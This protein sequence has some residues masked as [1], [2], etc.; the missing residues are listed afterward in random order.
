MV[1]SARLA[2]VVPG[3]EPSLRAS[4]ALRRRRCWCRCPVQTIIAR[5]PHA[6]PALSHLFAFISEQPR[7]QT[8]AR[9]AGVAAPGFA[10]A[11]V[12]RE[13][14]VRFARGTGATQL[15]PESFFVADITRGSALPHVVVSA[16]EARLAF[17]RIRSVTGNGGDEFRARNAL[18]DCGGGCHAV[19]G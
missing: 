12:V 17:R 11:H 15:A 9:E 8:H 16:F 13:R 2:G 18:G 5:V 19:A 14:A 10:T 3:I 1:R 4:L 7:I 6:P